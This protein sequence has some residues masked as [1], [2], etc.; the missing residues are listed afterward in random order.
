MQKPNPRT[1]N[2]LVEYT[3][4]NGPV[5]QIYATMGPYINETGVF[6]S[7]KT[8]G[9]KSIPRRQLPINP[10]THTR[11]INT[12]TGDGYWEAYIS[13]RRVWNRGYNYGQIPSTIAGTAQPI[14][15]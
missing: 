5:G 10:L 15:T 2:G 9:F 13:G 3:S 11:T 1:I 7:I 12:Y 4:V 6:T 14:Y 8:P